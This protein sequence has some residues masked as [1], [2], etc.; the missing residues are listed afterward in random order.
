M[1]DAEHEHRWARLPVLD[2]SV[3]YRCAGC[4]EQHRVLWGKL[5]GSVSEVDAKF[6]SS[7]GGIVYGDATPDFELTLAG[8]MRQVRALGL[9]L[10]AEDLDAAHER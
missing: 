9:T 8:R 6:T 4:P 3:T 7:A 5:E 10:D 1:S 2:L